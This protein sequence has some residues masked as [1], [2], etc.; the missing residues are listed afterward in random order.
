[1]GVMRS[2]PGGVVASAACTGAAG[3][4]TWPPKISSKATSPF[5]RAAVPR[6][7]VITPSSYEEG[8]HPDYS[9]LPSYFNYFLVVT[10]FLA[11]LRRLAFAAASG[12]LLAA[13]F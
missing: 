13:C 12:P 7:K 8:V 10:F 4:R 3:K 6:G 1:M 5:I 11:C 2:G 9:G